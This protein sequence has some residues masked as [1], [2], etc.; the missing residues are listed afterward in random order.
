MA[1]AGDWYEGRREGLAMK[2]AADVARALDV[3]AESPFTWPRWPGVPASINARRFVLSAFPF[4]VAYLP[5]PDRDRVVVLAVAHTSRRPGYW[6]E[7]LR[8]A[9]R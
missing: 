7:R 6:L 4:A 1:S 2:F 5:Q 8:E 3:I 9:S